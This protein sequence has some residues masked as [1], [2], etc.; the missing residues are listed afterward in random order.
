MSIMKYSCVIFI[1]IHIYILHVVYRLHVKSYITSIATSSTSMYGYMS[2]IYFV[3]QV[4]SPH[5]YLG[6]FLEEVQIYTQVRP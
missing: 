4:R 2:I 1:H 5:D 6:D 3:S